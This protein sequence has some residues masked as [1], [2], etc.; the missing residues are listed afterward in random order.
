MGKK[1]VAL[2]LLLLQILTLTACGNSPAGLTVHTIDDKYR[3]FYEVFVYSFADSDGDG[4]GDLSG[5]KEKLDYISDGDDSTDEDLGANGI[6]L[7]PIM[8]STTYHKYDVVDYLSIDSE[9]G[10]MEDFEQFMAA[11]EE[12]DIHVILDLVMNHTS[13]KHAWFLQACDYLRSLDD[14]AEPSEADCKYFGYYNF[15]KEKKSEVYYPVEGTDWYYEGKFWD[16]MPDLN[17]YN[18]N[19]RAEFEQIVDFW[20]D[21]GVSGF[22]LDAVKEFES[23][24]AQKNIEILS[25]FND[26]VKSRKE[27][28]YLVGEAW[29]DVSVYS[30]YY[31][32]GI[33]SFFDFQFADSGGIIA[34]TLKGSSNSTA[35]T[36]AKAIVSEQ[37]LFAEQNEAYI[38]AP[39][40]TNHDMGRSAGYYSGDPSEA[41][42]KIAQAMNLLMSGNAF[43]YYGEELGMKG[44]GKDENKRVGMYW[45]DDSD[46]PY[47]CDGPKDAD[48]VKQKFGSLETQ[49]EE[50]YS[51]YSYV[52]Q[53]I[54][55]RNTYPAIARGT[56]ENLDE[57]TNEH[58]CALKKT[59]EDE[60]LILIY[61]ISEEEQTLDLSEVTLRNQKLTEKNVSASLLTEEGQTVTVDGQTLTLPPYSVVI[62]Y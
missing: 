30:G 57:W 51:V 6:W 40:Y 3:T 59:Y 12:R 49:K 41:Q 44:S 48:S 52:K 38:N 21:K 29:S 60:E 15:T 46:A 33:D 2:L 43:L 28:V 22:R 5:L 42:T 53:V 62:L 19:V 17:L 26:M 9:Y 39:F 25:W 55:L 8:Q 1:R 13:A 35:K 61:N 47:M 4:I 31:A 58:I 32:S 24:Q 20:L 11:C 50:E 54:R 10:S 16:Q 18:E 14:G 37:E 56:N 36:Y 23:D 27:D 34:N 7:M 45:S